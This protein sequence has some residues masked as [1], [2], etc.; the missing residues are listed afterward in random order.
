MA[1]TTGLVASCSASHASMRCSI[2]SSSSSV[3]AR[4]IARRTY[5]A[6]KSAR[7][8]AVD[9]LALGEVAVD[10]PQAGSGGRPRVATS[11]SR[12]GL[13][14]GTGP[15]PIVEQIADGGGERGGVA[16]FDQYAGGAV[17]DDRGEPAHRGGHDR[18]AAGG[19]LECHQ[20][21]GLRPARHHAHVRGPVVGG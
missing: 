3:A 4:S 5:P 6:A 17:L 15:W 19:R 21:E 14:H 8:G 7:S 16:P 20:A 10:P 1:A 12:G 9:E 2:W 11:A 13:A 18:S